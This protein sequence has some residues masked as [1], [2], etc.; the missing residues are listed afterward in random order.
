MRQCAEFHTAVMTDL[1]LTGSD[2]AELFFVTLFT[3]GWPHCKH[4]D[5]LMD[6]AFGLAWEA[7]RE[8][9]LAD[10]LQ[11]G[12]VPYAYWVCER[13]WQRFT[14]PPTDRA[15]IEAALQSIRKEFEQ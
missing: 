6:S 12:E 15:T 14:Q 7:R 11:R 13:G 2:K 9:L 5:N 4:A 8:E 10:A 1:L 3:P